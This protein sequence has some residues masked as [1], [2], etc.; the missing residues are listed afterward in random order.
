MK[1]ILNKISIVLSLALAVS[2]CDFDTELQQNV[3]TADAFKNVQDVSNGTTGAYQA[4][5]NYPFLG[6]YAI[7]F[8]DFAGGLANGSASSGHFYSVSYWSVSDTDEEME[9]IWQY[10][11]KVV[12]A[13]VRTIN[14]ADALLAANPD[15][16]DDDKATIYYN[17]S[18]CYAL[19][20]LAYFTMTQYFCYPYSKG[21][22]QK[23]LPIVK[24][25]PVEAFQNATRASLGDTYSFML[26]DIKKALEYNE[27]AGS[28]SLQYFFLNKA[29]IYALKARVCLYMGNYADAEAAAK[30]AIELKGKGNA[31]YTDLTPNNETYLT[32]WASLNPSDEDIFTLSKTTD[33]NLSANALNTLWGS[34]YGKVSTYGQSFFSDTDVRARLIG[35]VDSN[36]PASMKWQGIESSQATSNI[37]IFRK[38]EMALIIAEC[39]ARNGNIT[40]AQKYVGYTAKRD[41][42]YAAE[43]GSCDL[44]KLPS[45]KD[46]LLEFIWKENTREFLGEGHFYSEARRLDKTVTVMAGTC[47]TF[48]PAN[49]V[50]PIP[51]AEINAGFMKDQN[52]GW[53]DGLPERD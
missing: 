52:T 15:M 38:S 9:G 43:D 42:Q 37:P 34:Y 36:S 3:D 24:D 32:M 26:D 45:D 51:A 7:A 12:D 40:E 48:R 41:S 21:A 25:Q 46:A 17:V 47:T 22:D 18:Q 28:P 8:G 53:E 4:L 20:A 29:A 2:S 19:R 13:A 10:G 1:K 14:G 11:F 31:T 35:V 6:N 33:D 27:E 50:F 49:F 16:S 23:G 44:S 39:E 5:A 30:K